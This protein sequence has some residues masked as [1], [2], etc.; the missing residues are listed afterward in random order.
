MRHLTF[1]PTQREA[2]EGRSPL[3]LG[4]QA[5]T[6]LS[7]WL[8]PTVVRAAFPTAPVASEDP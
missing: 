4:L 2:L 3:M 8:L 1:L 6:G 7:T 5:G